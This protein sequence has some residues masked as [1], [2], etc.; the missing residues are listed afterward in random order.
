MDARDPSGRG[1]HHPGASAGRSPSRRRRRGWRGW[2]SK[3]RSGLFCVDSSFS[4]D[5]RGREERKE[6]EG[7]ISVSMLNREQN[8]FFVLSGFSPKGEYPKMCCWLMDHHM[9]TYK[10][11]CHRW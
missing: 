7:M 11:S 2:R 8:I 1:C 3:D 10:S 5:A 9:I 4:E 6:K